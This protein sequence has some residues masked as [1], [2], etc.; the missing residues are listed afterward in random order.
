MRK[1]S[2]LKENTTSPDAGDNP[3]FI[4]DV[5]VCY[6]MPYTSH[7]FQRKVLDMMK[8]IIAYND[9]LNQVILYCTISNSFFY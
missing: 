5:R 3:A 8:I 9:E 1:N 2:D 6:D 4:I 7:N